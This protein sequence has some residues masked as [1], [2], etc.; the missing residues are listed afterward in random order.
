M[1]QKYFGKNISPACAYCE[2]GLLSQDGKNVLCPKGGIK[3]LQDS[4][5]KYQ[6]APLK[7]KPQL[8]PPLRR[9]DPKEFEL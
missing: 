9:Y 4:C 8:L 6:Y 5:A 3:E 1:K 2:W 7:R